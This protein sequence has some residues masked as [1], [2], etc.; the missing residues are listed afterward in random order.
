MVGVDIGTSRVKIVDLTSY[1]DDV[2]ITR[3]AIELAPPGAIRDGQIVALT[4]ADVISRG[5]A[6]GRIKPGAAIAGQESSS[7]TRSFRYA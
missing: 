3:D 6:E 2:E 1:N 5:L 4:V 7:D